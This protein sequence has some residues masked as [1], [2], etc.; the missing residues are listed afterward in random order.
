MRISVSYLYAITKYGYPHS[1]DDALKAF[2]EM[3]QLG[4]RF[5]EMEGL[6]KQNL[7]E[8]YNR[9]KEIRR[10]LDDCGLHVHN[11]CVVDPA[12][13]DIDPEIRKPALDRFQMGAE[14]AAFLDAETLHL[15]SYPPPVE[16]LQTP[17]YQLTGGTYRFENVTRLRLPNGFEWQ[18]VWE[19]LVSSVRFCADV[20][21]QYDRIVLM[22]PRVGEVI[23]SV[24]SLLRLIEQVDRP[25][26]KANLDTGHFSAQRENTVLSIAKLRGHF[27][28]VHVADNNPTDAEHL[29]IGDGSIDWK[30]FLLTLHRDG[31]SGYLG[32][33]LRASDNLVNEYKRSAVRLQE[34]GKEL[35][36]PM[37]I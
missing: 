37:E 17:P 9:R 35:D 27:A 19:T 36:I 18:P 31:Y 33:D 5:I 21:A 10:V 22:E 14:V 30:E 32:L 8:V 7:E 16:Y 1:V 15:A 23:C 12:M 28:N 20:A 29:A 4:F 24:D 13:T 2:V 34:L 11:F 25:N 3:R 26:L 6:G